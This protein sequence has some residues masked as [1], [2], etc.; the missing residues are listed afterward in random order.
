MEDLYRV[1]TIHNEDSCI[2]LAQA[3]RRLY[4][5]DRNQKFTVAGYV[6]IIAGGAL[7][8][9]LHQSAIAF[10]PVIIGCLLLVSQGTLAKIRAKQMMKS[11]G[12]QNLSV[13]YRFDPDGINIKNAQ[14]QGKAAY[15]SI[16]N[17][18]EKDAFFFLFINKST[19]HILPKKDFTFGDPASFPAFIENKTGLKMK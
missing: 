19:A 10:L 17:I 4:E 3:Q 13:D 18:A 12:G 7:F 5:A 2:A 15:S 1:N 16:V 14:R 11:M 8:A 9:L 6:C